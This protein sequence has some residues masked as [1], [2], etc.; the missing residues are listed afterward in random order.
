MAYRA[1]AI[2]SLA[3]TSAGLSL[4]TVSLALVGDYRLASLGAGLILAGV[5]VWG[6]AAEE[7][8]GEDVCQVVCGEGYRS[9]ASTIAGALGVEKPY[10]AVYPLRDAVLVA[11]TSAPPSGEP[12]SPG[13]S[14]GEGGYYFALPLRVPGPLGDPSRAAKAVFDAFYG[15]ASS[16]RVEGSE[17]G[18][19]VEVRGRIVRRPSPIDAALAALIAV[20]SLHSGRPLYLAG[21]SAEGDSV[22]MVLRYA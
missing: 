4:V 1:A 12:P 11:Y 6:F 21:L 10:V 2:L 9:L 14:A 7:A 16:V 13:I 8:V 15:S 18:A 3:L 5:G 22:R 17:D 19:R 20:F